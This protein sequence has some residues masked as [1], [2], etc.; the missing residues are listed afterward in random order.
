MPT[1]DQEMK[2]MFSK[3]VG[4]RHPLGIDAT[5]KKL[6]QVHLLREDV[7]AAESQRLCR[8]EKHGT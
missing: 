5:V 3:R 8:P 4:C 1:D 7:L 6:Y 2:T